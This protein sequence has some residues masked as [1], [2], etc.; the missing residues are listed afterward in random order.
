[1]HAVA[2]RLRDD[3]RDDHVIA[4]ALEIDDGQV[5]ALL[6]IAQSKLDSLMN[7]DNG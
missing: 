3:G 4:V 1:M 2:V 7:L 5:P 6:Q